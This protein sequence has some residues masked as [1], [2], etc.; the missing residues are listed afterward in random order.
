MIDEQSAAEP[1]QRRNTFWR[2]LPI[3][4]GVAIVVAILVRAFVL[5]TFYIPSESMEHTLNINDRVL[6]NKLVYDFR[7]PHRGEIIVF[8]S[9]DSWR[10]DPTETD[11]IKRVIGIGGDRVQCCDAQHRLEINGKSLNEPYL[12]HDGGDNQSSSP[13]QFDVVVPKGRLWVMGDNRFHSGDSR[14]QYERTHDPVA[15]TISV[16]AV[17]GRAFVIFWPFSRAGWLSIPA[18]YNSIPKSP[19]G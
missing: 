11:F 8:N 15:S 2:E 5:Q 4:L 12:D 13:N 14:E 6:V 9:P 19:P 7:D 18:S 16:S 3:L 10:G 17:V 1:A